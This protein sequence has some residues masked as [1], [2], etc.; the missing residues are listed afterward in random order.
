MNLLFAGTPAFAAAHLTSLLD[1]GHCIKA[2]LTQPDKP[3]K[4]GKRPVSSPVKRLAEARGLPVLQPTKLSAQ[5][6]HD[7]GFGDIDLMIVVAYGQILRHDVLGLPRHG[8]INV[9]ASLLPRWRGAAPIQRALL[10]GDRESGIC[11]MQMD[12]DL[13]TGD[14]LYRAS[15]PIAPD[16]TSATLADRF[17]VLGCEGLEV[18]I[19]A[20]AAGN[21]APQPQSGEATYAHKIDKHEA[22][23]DWQQP[24]TVIDRQVRA[25][26]PEPVAFCHFNELRVKV[27]QTAGVEPSRQGAA[28]ELLALTK[29]GLLVACG[30][31][32]LWL[33]AVQLPL[34]KGSVLS[35]ADILNSRRDLFTP[36]AL[37][38]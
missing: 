23:I 18:V 31:G 37:F 6:L 28:G 14:V 32:A 7:S 10:A 1:H 26:N 12:A 27:W 20:V 35:G 2:V 13:D 11:I 16:D 8:C 4:R 9:H 36:G 15:T 24:A 19:K 5:F 17:V 30:E 3:G 29:Q 21:V 25:F 34:G 38:S 33:R 22:Q